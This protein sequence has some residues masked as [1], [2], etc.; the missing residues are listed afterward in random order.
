MWQKVR[1][2]WRF[3]GTHYADDFDFFFIGGDDL[4]VLP[5][6]LRNYLKSFSPDEDHFL[7]RRLKAQ[8]KYFNSGGAGYTLS[9]SALRKF[10]SIGLDHP[11]CDPKGRTS[12]EDVMIAE[13]LARVLQIHFEDT[14]DAQGR[15]RFHPLSPGS[16]YSWRPPP[17]RHWYKLYNEEWGLKLGK[18]CCAP[19]LVSFHY[20]KK[21]AMVRHLHSLLYNCNNDD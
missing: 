4:F 2:I 7:G 15:E 9:R 16:H 6:N 5:Q 12:E 21:P 3:V 19:D 11:Q 10:V 18:D 14:R 13:C 1:S 20:I 17:G 8:G